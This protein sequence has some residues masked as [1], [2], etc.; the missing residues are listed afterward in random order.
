M[1]DINFNRETPTYDA[2][3]RF[4][5]TPIGKFEPWRYMDSERLQDIMR[6]CFKGGDDRTKEYILKNYHHEKLKVFK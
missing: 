4:Y 5:L 3:A 6:I 1:K 2:V